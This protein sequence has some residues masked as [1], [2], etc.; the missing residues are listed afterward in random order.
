[1]GAASKIMPTMMTMMKTSDLFHL[2]KQGVAFFFKPATICLL[3]FTWSEEELL[4][5]YHF[6]FFSISFIFSSFGVDIFFIVINC[7]DGYGEF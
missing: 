1:M 6:I 5:I 7:M 2:E 3:S 4:Y